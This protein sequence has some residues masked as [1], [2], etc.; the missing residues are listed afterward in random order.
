MSTLFAIPLLDRIVYPALRRFG[1]NF[2]PLRRMA[3]GYFC[4]IVSVILAGVIEIARKEVIK[5][6]GTI[7]QTVFG[8]SVNAS[9]VSVFYQVPQYVLIGMSEALAVI[10]SKLKCFQLFP[11]QIKLERKLKRRV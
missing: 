6:D 10:T 1:F 11:N 7:T 4:G 3:A 8:R 5:S 9:S 2:T